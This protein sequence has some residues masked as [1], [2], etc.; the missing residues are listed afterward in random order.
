MSKPYLENAHE[1]LGLRWTFVPM[2]VALTAL[3]ASLI[4]P[5]GESVPA[6]IAPSLDAMRA[7]ASL[8]GASSPA[9]TSQDG[10]TAVQGAVP[11][12]ETQEH[13]HAPTF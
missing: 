9:A 11:A 10:R 13:E 6:D 2:T 1:T 3:V 4:L 12:I 7:A 8:T 5:V